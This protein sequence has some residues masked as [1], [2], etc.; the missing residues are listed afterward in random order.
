[1]VYLATTFAGFSVYLLLSKLDNRGSFIVDFGEG[2]LSFNEWIAFLPLA[3]IGAI[4]GFFYFKLEFTLEKLIH[5]FREYKLTLGI[6]G[7]ILLG[8]AGTFLPYTL[9]SGE[10]Q[11]K[12]LVV[13]WSHLSFWILLLS[14]ILKLCITAVCLNTGWRGGHIFPIIF[15]GSS[16]GYAVA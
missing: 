14:G 9:F 2:A 16:I 13:E 3:S 8:I 12:E 4:V 6:I 15:S 10:H 11:L 1:I 5:P 7:G